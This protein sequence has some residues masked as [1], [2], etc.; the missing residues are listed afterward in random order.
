VQIIP[1]SDAIGGELTFLLDGNYIYYVKEE[2]K[3]GLTFGTLYQVPVLGGASK[4][5]V[6][7]VDS[8]VAISP[9][10]KQLAFV[11]GYPDNQETALVVVN[12]DGSAE[13]K[14]ATRKSPGFAAEGP[15]W[16]PDG[17][18]IAVGVFDLVQGSQRS[19]QSVVVVN[20]RDG[21]EQTFTSKEWGTV[22]RVA[23]LPDGS[24][25]LVVAFSE[26]GVYQIW[27]L[28]YPSGQV[29]RVTNDTN[30][31]SGVSVT[32]DGKTLATASTTSSFSLWTIAQGEWSH[33]RDISPGTS[34]ADGGLGASWMP[35]G[36]ILYT[37]PPLKS[38]LGVMNRDGSNP[39]EFPVG[40]RARP[41]GVSAC[42]D[43]KY[44]LLSSRGIVRVDSEGGNL[45]HLT[46]GDDPLDFYP[47]CSP[48]GQ[49]VGYLSVKVPNAQW[50]TLW[51]IPIEGGTPVQLRSAPTDWFAISHDGKWIAC[52]GREDPNQPTKLMVLP[53]QG[54]P[55]SKTFDAP[56]GS[57]L[58]AVDWAPDGRL[59]TFSAWQKGASNVWTQPLAGGPPKQL[60][61][62][63]TGSTWWFA[64]SLDGKELA[65][66]RQTSTSDAMLISNFIGSEK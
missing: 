53:S 19:V 62:F 51:K 5:L 46:T 9:D 58:Y 57:E 20:V 44:V 28:G 22:G 18:V 3:G 16:S 49:W 59:L 50:R 25:V 29:R 65:L 31:Y 56:A 35:D 41:A 6:L 64:W 32:A 2:S 48:D 47:R 12:E 34:K 30:D 66:V 4:K 36:R 60:T 15:S 33:P 13:R 7:D 23:W 39:K 42:P 63:E 61:N 52:T 55:P 26:G 14:L 21:K 43:G 40:V 11:R 37:S 24:G 38:N 8:P 10:G 17:K 54:G 27:H 45:K 1:P